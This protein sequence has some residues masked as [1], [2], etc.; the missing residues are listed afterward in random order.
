[1]NRPN[2]LFLMSDEHRFDVAG[3]AGN[4]VV[5]TPVLDG[6]ARSGVVFDNAYTPSPVCVPAR[7]SL[8]SG[9]LPA[10]TGCR[11][12]G[13]DLPGGH[14]TFARLFA[15]YGYLTVACGKLHRMGPDQMQGWTRRFGADAMVDAACVDDRVVGVTA[16]RPSKWNQAREVRRAVAGEAFHDRD[17]RMAVDGARYCIGRHFVDGSSDRAVPEVPLLLKVSLLQPHYPYIVN[18]TE[19][20][21]Y[22]LNRVE[23]YANDER[24]DHPILAGDA[25]TVVRAGIEVTDRELRRALAAYYAMVETVDARFGQVLAALRQAGQDLDDWIIV[26]TADHGEMLG[27]HGLFEKQK[28][29]EGSVRV[30]LIVRWPARFGPR[31]VAENVSLCDLFATLCDL[32]GLPIPDGLDSRSLAG[33]LEGRSD[34]WDDETVSEFDGVNLM[35]KRGA[36][37]YQCYRAQ[38]PEVLFDLAHDPGETANLI[39]EPR[40][41]REV[42]AFRA[43]VSAL[44]FGL[45]DLRPSPLPGP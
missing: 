2:V 19:L 20:L 24:F 31:R 18:D 36:L 11:R 16:P 35:I 4:Q 42:A 41:V 26:Y 33:L 13:D 1:M 45:A 27:E 8:A 40:Y 22:Y 34:G 15:Q 32:A 9:Q 28:F 29:F 17:D 44:G 30:P 38:Q 10:T 43:R 23:P 14:M 25:R 12:H 6:L 39:D 7:Q 3:F 5:R 21:G 37:K